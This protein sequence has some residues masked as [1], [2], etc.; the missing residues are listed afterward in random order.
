VNDPEG[1]KALAIVAFMVALVLAVFLA[2]RKRT[3]LESGDP[4]ESTDRTRAQAVALGVEAGILNR[5]GEPLCVVCDAVATRCTV[6]TGKSWFD[7]IPFLSMLNRLN[8]MPWR[9]TV[10]DDWEA[11]YRLCAVHRRAAEQRLEQLHHKIRAEH[12]NFNAQQQQKIAMLDQGGLEQ[13]LREDAEQIQRSIGL[14]G[15]LRASLDSVETEAE[16]H[17]LPVRSTK[18]RRMDES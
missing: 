1:V 17:M 6:R 18:E 13:L 12:A 16:V 5:D 11:G 9:Y 4:S 2:N 3:E 15:A 10:E 7:K 8:A 14:R